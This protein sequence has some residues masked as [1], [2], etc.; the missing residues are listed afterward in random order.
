MTKN[1]VIINEV[2]YKYSK[3]CTKEWEQSVVITCWEHNY[4]EKCYKIDYHD[5][6]IQTEEGDRP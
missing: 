6:D 2:E 5:K 1:R 3:Y 4:E